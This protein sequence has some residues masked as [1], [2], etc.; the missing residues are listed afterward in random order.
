MTNKWAY[1]YIVTEIIIQGAKLNVTPE[2]VIAML[3]NNVETA[4]YNMTKLNGEWTYGYENMLK[5]FYL[6]KENKN[7][8]IEIIK[9]AIKNAFYKQCDQDLNIALDEKAKIVNSGL[10]Q[11]NFWIFTNYKQ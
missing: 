8:I 6:I 1:I 7:L 3:K 10:T 5:D 9:N 4:A 11:A 2:V